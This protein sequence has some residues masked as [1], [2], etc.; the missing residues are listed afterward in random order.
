MSLDTPAAFIS[1]FG[2]ESPQA[3]LR[4]AYA[5]HNTR[6]AFMSF[7]LIG[8]DTTTVLDVFRC[9]MISTHQFDDGNWLM[10]A[11]LS[12][13]IPLIVCLMHV[14]STI[15][16]RAVGMEFYTHIRRAGYGDVFTE[17]ELITL[18]TKSTYLKKR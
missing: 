9:S 5:L 13:Y 14:H 17:Y 16:M 4:R 15:K 8:F 18:P 12:D 11:T 6:H 1:T 2:S 10:S 7:M 3:N